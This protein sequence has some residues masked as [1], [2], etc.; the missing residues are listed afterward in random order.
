MGESLGSFLGAGLHNPGF[1]LR[2]SYALTAVEFTEFRHC[3]DDFGCSKVHSRR[4]VLIF[5]LW[6]GRELKIRE[7]GI[8]CQGCSWRGAGAELSTGL[9]RITSTAMYFYAYR[10]PECLSYDVARPAR[11]LQFKKRAE[12]TAQEEQETPT[13]SQQTFP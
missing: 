13:Q 9:V 1:G 10:C 4:H 6:V 11:L 2:H 5:M 7:T 8:V 3:V 12:A